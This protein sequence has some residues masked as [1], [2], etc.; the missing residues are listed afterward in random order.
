MRGKT[1]LV[2]LASALAILLA[3]SMVFASGVLDVSKSS[4]FSGPL[5]ELDSSADVFVDPKNTVD[6]TKQ[7][8]SYVTVHINITGAVDLFTWQ[9][10]IT[11]DKNIL[12]VYRIMN[13]SF[14]GATR[15]TSSEVLGFVINVTD[16]AD[17]NEVFSESVLGDVSGIGGL[18]RLVSINFTVVGYGSTDI[19][20]NPL[21]NL[22]TT[23][24]N[25]LGATITPMIINGY[26][27]NKYTGDVDGD[28]YVGSGDV[29]ILRLSYGY[30]Y[31]NINYN[32]ECDFD[33]DGYVGSGDVNLLRPNYGIT[34]P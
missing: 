22:N 5:G 32:R 1:K 25:S 8:G 16:V 19:I 12:N 9:I 23:L 10:N 34:F 4:L 6:S 26:F 7:S 15:N 2:S 29:N 33:M 13:S 31:P 21:G 18:G 24:L 20:I 17:G 28:K 30:S 14:L 11:Y 3:V 27:R